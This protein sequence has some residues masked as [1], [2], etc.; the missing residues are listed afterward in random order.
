MLFFSNSFNI[1]GYMGVYLYQYCL[2]DIHKYAVGFI[3][4]GWQCPDE[5][6]A[7]KDNG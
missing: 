4:R 7:C 3:G 1:V 2:T 6:A 5:A